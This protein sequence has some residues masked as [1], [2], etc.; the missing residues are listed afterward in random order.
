MEASKKIHAGEPISFDDAT[1]AKWMQVKAAPTPKLIFG[2]R[3][4]SWIALGIAILLGIL[5]GS[6]FMGLFHL[7]G[8]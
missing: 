1:L 5:L 6:C 8:I 2:E 3:K 7:L 4:G